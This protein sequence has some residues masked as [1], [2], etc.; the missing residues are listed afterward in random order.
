[1]IV[2]VLI[3]CIIDQ[4][5]PQI[6]FN[7]VKVLEKAGCIVNYNTEQTCCGKIAYDSGYRDDCK[8]IGTKLINEFNSDRYIV[9][10]STACF[11][12]IK[13]SY[14]DLFF[15]SVLHNEYKQVQRNI[16]EL[17]DFLINIVKVQNVGSVFNGKIMLIDNCETGQC[18]N[19]STSMIT[20]LK[21]VQGLTFTEPLQTGNC[22]GFNGIFSIKNEPLSVKLAEEKLTAA[23]EAGAGYLVTAEPGCLLQMDSII[24]QKN[25]PVKVLHLADI[26]ANTTN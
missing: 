17:S 6:G 2:N 19:Q 21:Q 3:P 20:L 14:S 18:K 16:Y 13:N 4:F 5:Y 10:P 11:G 7:F 26:L 9:T 22:C 8:E 25:A 24:K 1:M 23:I 15:N 12:T